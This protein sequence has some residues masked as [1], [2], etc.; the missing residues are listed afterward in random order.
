MSLGIDRARDERL[1]ALAARTTE[2]CDAAVAFLLRFLFMLALV[3]GGVWTL[4]QY[5]EP[6]A[7]ASLCS[8]VPLIRQPYV[9]RG[10]RWWQRLVLRA[11]LVRL[12][13]R[14]RTMLHDVEFLQR[15]VALTRSLLDHCQADADEA[16]DQ[17]AW[18]RSDLAK[19]Q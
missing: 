14:H 7:A 10:P 13:A 9:G 5:F 18:A 1:T 8:A 4:L 11:R 16:A 12:R 17:I 3:L 6:C 19:L 2:R 15:E